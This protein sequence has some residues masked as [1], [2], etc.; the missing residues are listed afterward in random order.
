MNNQHHSLWQWHSSEGLPYL[1]CSLLSHWQH[2][3]FTQHFAPRTPE[4][5]VQ[6]L[7]TQA[8]A[9]RL[10]QI[11]GN[12]VLT[13]RE[14]TILQRGEESILPEGD[15]IISDDSLQALWVAS[16]DCTPVLIG[17]LVTGKVAALHSGWRGTAQK[18]APEAINKFLA[19]GSSLENLRIAL[20]PAIA[21]EV[22]QVNEEVALQVASSVFKE[23]GKDS[24]ILAELAQ[25]AHA[26]ILP[27]P[28]PGKLR[29][30]VRQIIT[31]QLEQ[32]GIDKEQIA[33]APYCTYQQPEHFF[34]Y[35]RTQLKQ[36]QWSGIVS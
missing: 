29:L 28:I 21:G 34:S 4:E 32:L 36:V 19:S 13:P 2:G 20:G 6:I 23:N 25:L 27:D 8:Q 17:D 18:I 22:Y 24:E 12:Q 3:F 26:P 30:D 31:L 11:H 15:G 35:R 1:T 9:Y 7:H 14:I 5:L 10:K 33:L 16:A